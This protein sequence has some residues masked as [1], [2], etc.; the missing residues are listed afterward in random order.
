MDS[1]IIKEK[2]KNLPHIKTVW[3]IGNDIWITPVSGATK[4]DLTNSEEPINEE[5]NETPINKKSKKK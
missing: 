3:V 4:V 1:A 2:Y 5:V